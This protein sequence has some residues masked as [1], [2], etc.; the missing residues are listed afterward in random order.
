MGQDDII[1]VLDCCSKALKRREHESDATRREEMRECVL[2][3]AV[4]QVVRKVV[5]EVAEAAGHS[6]DPRRVETDQREGPRQIS[7]EIRVEHRE[8]LRLSILHPPLLQQ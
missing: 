7:E 4:Q 1:F 8:E 6:R 5:A 3:E 2:E